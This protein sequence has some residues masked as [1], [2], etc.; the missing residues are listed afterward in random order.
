MS[1][2]DSVSA[3]SATVSRRLPHLSRAHA[4]VL[5]LWSYGM[6]LAHTCGITTVVAVLAPLVGASENTLRQRLREW[7]Y[8][9]QHKR[10]T[11]RQAIQVS[12][13]FAPLLRWVLA[14][15]SGD[16]HRLALVLDA[17]TL[18]ARFSVL[19][20][21]VVYRGCAIPVAWKLVR[22]H[23][24]GTWQPHWKGLLTHLHASVPADWTVL[25]LADRGLYA[26]WLYEAIRASGWHPF[27]RVNAGGTYRPASSGGLRPLGSAVQAVGERWCGEVICFQEPRSRLACTLVACWEPGHRERWLVLTDFLPE[28]AQA[29]WYSLRAWIEAGFK[30][31]KRGG[32]QWHQTKMTDPA[33]AERL[34]LAMAVATLWVVSIGGEVDATRPASSLEALP[35]T[36]VARRRSCPSP[37]RRRQL[38]CFRRGQLLITGRL[39]QGRALPLGRFLPEPWPDKQ[40]APGPTR[41]GVAQTQ[42]RKTYP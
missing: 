13:C 32:W 37:S 41:T 25:V 18:G 24:K 15:W 16:E 19:A 12:A 8:D 3:W 11:H 29:V 2:C 6:V 7:C 34:W 21:S 31:L 23:A 33:R 39:V 10:G 5:A 40:A 27:L 22:T 26:R 4:Q 28:Q 9:A 42:T 36:H 1:R 20:I 35:P 17:S 38:S 14:W 30:D